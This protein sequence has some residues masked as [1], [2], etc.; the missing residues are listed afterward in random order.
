M[1]RIV[2]LLSGLALTGCFNDSLDKLSTHQI[3]AAPENRWV[4]WGQENPVD[5]SDKEDRSHKACQRKPVD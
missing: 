1:K 4:H 2:F 3:I 5:V